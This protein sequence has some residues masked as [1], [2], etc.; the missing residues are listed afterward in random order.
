MPLFVV[1]PFWDAMT[2]A[3]N[4]YVRYEI[5]SGSSGSEQLMSSVGE[6]IYN[7]LGDTIT[8]SSL[9]VVEWRNMKSTLLNSDV[10]ISRS[11]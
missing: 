8:V 6:Y 4:G 2:P 11:T 10:S 7:V 3:D 1:A 5:H 9:L